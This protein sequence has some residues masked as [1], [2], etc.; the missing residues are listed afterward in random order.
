MVCPSY[1][2][3]GQNSELDPASDFKHLPRIRGVWIK[4]TLLSPYGEGQ[5]Y[6]EDTE[7]GP[8]TYGITPSQI[9]KYSALLVEATFS[10]ELGSSH[11]DTPFTYVYC[12]ST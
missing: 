1:G 6:D 9:F 10:E 12:G 4:E 5:S 11:C 3:D 8:R 7:L 2:D